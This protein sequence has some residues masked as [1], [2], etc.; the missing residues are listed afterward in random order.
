MSLTVKTGG[1]NG[2]HTLTHSGVP[3]ERL[4]LGKE[5]ASSRGEYMAQPKTSEARLDPE[6]PTSDRMLASLRSL[7]KLARSLQDP[8]RAVELTAAEAHLLLQIGPR[9]PGWEAEGTHRR[10]IRLS[11]IKPAGFRR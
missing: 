8:S 2:Q 11:Q 5:S 3:M 4:S 9:L 10:A 6:A 7:E 1:E